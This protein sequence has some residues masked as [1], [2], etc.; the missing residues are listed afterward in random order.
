M[1]PEIAHSVCLLLGEDGGDPEFQLRV[2]EVLTRDGG[3]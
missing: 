2:E 3:T 1:K